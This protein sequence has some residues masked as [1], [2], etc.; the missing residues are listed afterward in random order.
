[1][2]HV[3]NSNVSSPSLIFHSTTAMLLFDSKA[4]IGSWQY[5]GKA[6]DSLGYLLVDST[7]NR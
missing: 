3:G 1:M 7:V 5:K 4:W 2:K 6:S